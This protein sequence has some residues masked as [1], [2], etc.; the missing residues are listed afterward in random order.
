MGDAEPS[1][2]LPGRSRREEGPRTF[3]PSVPL[4]RLR[5]PREALPP[6]LPDPRRAHRPPREG[7]RHL[8]E[9][10]LGGVPR[11]RPRHRSRARGAR[12]EAGRGGLDPLRG[13]QGVDL[14]R[15]RRPVRRRYRLRHL[16]DRQRRA[17]RVPAGGLA[18]PVPRRGERGAARQ[19][20]GRPR[21][22][23]GGGEVHRARPRRPAR[24]LRRLHP[25]PRRAVRPRA[26]SPRGRPR[27]LPARG[28]GVAPRRRRVARLHLRHHRPAEGGDD[29][30]REHHLLGGVGP[31]GDADPGG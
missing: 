29:H 12:A 30:A 9:P 14:R 28:R 1:T 31:A 24:P 10:F 16:P 8:E 15:P 26:R 20:P 25:V 23:A 11:R 21:P 7:A 13:P 18:K 19:V 2:R 5:H 4:R 22:G 17:G 3:R 27:P 6:P